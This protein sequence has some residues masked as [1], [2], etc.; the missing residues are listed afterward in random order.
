MSW[1][2]IIPLVISVT[3]A[4]YTYFGLHLKTQ[5]KI[6]SVENGL[7]VEI[8]KIA[9]DLV[10]V[11]TKHETLCQEHIKQLTLLPTIDNRQAKMEAQLSVYF[12]TLDPFLAA[13]I[14]S[15]KH[16]ERDSLMD[17]F[18]H[19]ILT[20]E[21]AKALE[22][23]LEKAIREETDGNKSWIEILAL[24]R[25]RSIIVGMEFDQQHQKLGY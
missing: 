21:D 23:E 7:R 4:L 12:K 16:I 11:D 10:R 5:D 25:V 9:T 13:A 17:K 20:Y 6:N 14:H 1:T 18:E 15:P 8:N 3:L 2:S 24:G 22:A 19:E